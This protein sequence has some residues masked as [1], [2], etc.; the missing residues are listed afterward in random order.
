MKVL[1]ILEDLLRKLVLLAAA[2]KEL[3]GRERATAVAWH[4]NHP[5]NESR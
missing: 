4:M 2:V 5:P 1:L 3:R